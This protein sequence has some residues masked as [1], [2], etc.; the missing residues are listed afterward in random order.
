MAEKNPKFADALYKNGF[1]VADEVS[2]LDMVR[3]DMYRAK[4]SGNTLN[5]VIAP[6]QNCNFGCKYCY[7]KNILQSME[8]NIEVQ[9]AVVQYIRENISCGGTLHVCWYGGEPLLGLEIIEKL[10]KELL[11]LCEEKQVKYSSNIITNGYLL[12]ASTA[13]RLRKCCITQIQITLDGDEETHNMRR[14]LANGGATYKTIWENLFG[15]KRYKDEIKVTL[16][17]NVDKE[18]KYALSTIR[19]KVRDAHLDDFVLVYP[20]KVMGYEGCHKSEVCYSTKEFAQLEQEFMSDDEV[21]LKMKYPNPRFLSCCAEC[22][23]AIVIDYQGDLYKCYMDIGIEKRCVGN[24][25]NLQMKHEEVLYEY[26]LSDVTENLDCKVCKYLPLC[27]GGCR[28]DVD[29]RGKSCTTYKYNLD[30]YM[31]NYFKVIQK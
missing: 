7:E 28:K 20:G 13:E 15:L 16:R 12:N 30:R 3:F 24:V 22:L 21:F 9:D 1:A 6:T 29:G 11:N 17:V 27:M 23:N 8:M 18:N 26:M 19:E 10:T 5:V 2:E 31:T 14:P 4:F 25:C